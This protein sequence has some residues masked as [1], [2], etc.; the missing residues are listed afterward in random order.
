[1]KITKQQLKQIIKEEIVVIKES[2]DSDLEQEAR[3]ADANLTKMALA[4]QKIHENERTRH[5]AQQMV[6]QLYRLFGSGE[7]IELDL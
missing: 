1:M 5:K 4:I 6:D 2:N 3:E 7:E